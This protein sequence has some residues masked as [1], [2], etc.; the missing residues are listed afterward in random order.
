MAG[1]VLAPRIHV[2]VLCDEVEPAEAEEGTYNLHGVRTIIQAEWFP[3]SHPLLTIYMQMTGH[4]NVPALIYLTIVNAADDSEVAR[5]EVEELAFQGPL[6]VISFRFQFLDC[7]F[8]EPGLYYVQ[9][10]SGEKLISE[11]PLLLL[12]TVGNTNG[13]G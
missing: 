1:N 10:Y 13:Q 8:P 4:E 7:V 3:Y 12:Q 5:T 2:L 11:R 6:I 9:A